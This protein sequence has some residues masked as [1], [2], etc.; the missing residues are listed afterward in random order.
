[1]AMVPLS[2]ERMAQLEEFAQRHGQDTADALDTALAE[3]LTWEEHDFQE[4]VAAIT[5][6]YSQMQ[7]GQSQ[8]AGEVFEELRLKHGLPR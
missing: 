2:T 3:Y 1:M 4:A 7:A 5:E 6:G 8:P